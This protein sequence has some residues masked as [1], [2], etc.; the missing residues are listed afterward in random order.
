LARATQIS[1]ILR[2]I[3]VEAF[4]QDIFAISE[5]RPDD[6]F[7]S[8][9][10]VINQQANFSA[11]SVDLRAIAVIDRTANI[12]QAAKA[13]ASARFR[14][15]GQSPYAP[16]IVLVHEFIL[17]DF[18]ES[19]TRESWSHCAVESKESIA[20]HSLDKSLLKEI[21][22]VPGTRIVISGSNWGIIEVQDR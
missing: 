4:D 10:V 3:L 9:T 19:V 11:S 18:I 16:D 5:Q 8:R 7:L 15:G 21:E 1:A 17:K 14:F 2:K 6:E 20:K 13:L 22:H 12:S